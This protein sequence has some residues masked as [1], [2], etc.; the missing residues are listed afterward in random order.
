MPRKKKETVNR[1]IRFDPDVAEMLDF[2]AQEIAD[3]SSNKAVNRLLRHRLEDLGVK[4][5][6]AEYKRQEQ[7]DQ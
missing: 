1:T 6:L 4:E 7:S 3:E 5:R 2:Y